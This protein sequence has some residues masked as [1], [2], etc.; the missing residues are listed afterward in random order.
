MVG[1]LLSWLLLIRLPLLI[2]QINHHAVVFVHYFPA[3]CASVKKP[4]AVQL[5]FLQ[6]TEETPP[7]PN[8]KIVF[9]VQETIN[10]PIKATFIKRRSGNLLRR[11]LET[12][13]VN[14][15]KELLTDYPLIS[16]VNLFMLNTQHEL[17]NHLFP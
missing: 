11:Q 4:S 7:K 6:A 16:T 2:T 17:A 14:V 8:F 12:T 1:L 5:T 13:A 3:Q 15:I 9:Q 10:K